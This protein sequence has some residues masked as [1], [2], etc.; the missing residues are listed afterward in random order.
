MKYSYGCLS[1]FVGVL[2]AACRPA[3]KVPVASA[4]KNLFSKDNLVAWCIVPYDSKKRSPD[5]RAVMLNTLGITKMAYDWRE[6]HIPS[7]DAELTALKKHG[8]KLEAFWYM[9]GLA[10]EKDSTLQ[11]VFN[12]LERHH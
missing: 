10:P 4:P 3:A 11:L 12:L 6:E 8:I 5:E 2:L 9:S 1:I 7:F